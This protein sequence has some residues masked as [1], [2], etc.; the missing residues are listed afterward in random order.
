[1]RLRPRAFDATLVGVLTLATQLE[2]WLGPYDDRVALSG[3]LLATTLPLLWRR[4]RP[5]AACL[6]AVLAF[7]AGQAVL[8]TP[9]ELASG[10]LPVLVA[11]GSGAAHLALREALGFGAAALAAVW[12]AVAAS[13]E[14][15]TASNYA[16]ATLVVGVAWAVGR[17]LSVRHA[18]LALVQEQAEVA[19]ADAVARERARIARELH[20]V[21][22]HGVSVM[23]L[24]A[25][26]AK[27]V[28]GTRPDDARTALEAVQESGRA[29]LVELRRMLD[30]LRDVDGADDDLQPQPGLDD[31]TD[32]VART[33]AAGL[34][35]QLVVDTG[36]A[37]VPAAV[38]LSAYRI[39][40]EALTN[41][42]KHAGPATASVTVGVD[43]GALVVEVADTGR[44]QAAGT[45]GHGLV[46]MRERVS[47][48]GG[49]LDVVPGPG[50]AVRAR[51]P[52]GT[53]A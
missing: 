26:A 15:P 34:R 37:A 21:V 16:Y 48:F 31:L 42:L 52:L 22:A 3:F 2:A 13:P 49:S 44:G 38:G 1:V 53:A 43:D 28:L 27:E 29:A 36:A 33:T 41:S 8:G 23:V 7:A 18:Q 45:A 11:V 5:M 30:V 10:T 19:A 47:V 4:T 35:T 14:P 12:V 39:V 25:G 17:V 50:F 51:L 24:Q 40:Q 9:T 32:L 6:G 20:D 46:G